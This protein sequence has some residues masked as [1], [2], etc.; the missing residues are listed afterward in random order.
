MT[1]ETKGRTDRAPPRIRNCRQRTHIQADKETLMH[2][3]F[4]RL[5][6]V[7]LLSCGLLAAPHAARAAQSYDNCNNFIDTLPATIS[8][9][10]VWCLRHD[11]STAI[12]T[13][14]AITIN[15][16]NVTIDCNDFKIGGLAAGDGSTTNGIYASGRQNATVRHCNLRGFYCGILLNSGAGHLVEDNRL[17]NSLNEGIYVYGE[18]SRVRRNA[19]Y[20]T[21]GSTG[22]TDTYGI[23]SNGD[24]IDNT[25]SGLFADKSGGVLTGIRPLAA[26]RLVRGNVVSGFN[27]NASTGGSVVAVN[28]ID[29]FSQ[30]IMI[31]GNSVFGPGNIGT[32]IYGYGGSNNFCRDN[33]VANFWT[34]INSCTVAD[35]N[36]N[37]MTSP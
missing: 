34:T 33:A 10:G 23:V 20:D 2:S 15:A 3:P 16:N 36:G 6:V 22:D 18:N 24:I 25:V 4:L 32:G 29:S 12:T 26:V 13:G 5:F 11:L 31:E 7:V 8:T 37:N 19:V 14:N 30:N 9:Q 21:G 35:N 17:D 28:G 1:L 27:T